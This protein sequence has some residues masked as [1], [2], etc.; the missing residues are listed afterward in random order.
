[1]KLFPFSL[2]S[3]N[4]LSFLEIRELGLAYRLEIMITVSERWSKTQESAYGYKV[5]NGRRDG[6]VLCVGHAPPDRDER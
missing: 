5:V 4:N 6:V 3:V 2:F 1:M